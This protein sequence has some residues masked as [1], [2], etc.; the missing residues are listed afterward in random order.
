MSSLETDPGSFH[1]LH[2]RK[3]FPAHFITLTDGSTCD[4]RTLDRAH[5][6]LGD[7]YDRR[8]GQGIVDAHVVRDAHGSGIEAIVDHL[9]RPSEKYR[10]GKLGIHVGH[11]ALS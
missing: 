4:A 8:I 11:S 5:E 2:P 10:L 3:E 9:P 7:V 6:V 1:G